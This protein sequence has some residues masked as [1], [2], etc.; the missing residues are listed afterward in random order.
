MPARERNSVPARGGEADGAAFIG[1]TA[2]RG[3]A[4]GSRRVHADRPLSVELL[5]DADTFEHIVVAQA[6]G[7]AARRLAFLR[8]ARLRATKPEH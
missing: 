1:R 5:G 6:G 8:P 4:H 3:Q 2:E 7:H